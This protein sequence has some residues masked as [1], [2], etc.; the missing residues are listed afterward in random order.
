MPMKINDGLTNQQRYALTL[1]GRA[2][3]QAANRAWA[4]RNRPLSRTLAGAYTHKTRKERLVWLG[5]YKIMCG[6]VDCG[7]R[8]DPRALQFDHV[9]GVKM[10]SVSAMITC[11]LEHLIAEIEKCEIRCSNCHLIKTHPDAWTPG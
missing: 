5:V 3:R 1:N 4:E 10:K 7:Y 2:R 6:C 8:D 9:R 11:S